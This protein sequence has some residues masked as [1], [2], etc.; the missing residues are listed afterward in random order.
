MMMDSDILSVGNM[1]GSYVWFSRNLT[2]SKIL[3]L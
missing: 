2:N 1:A 3:R